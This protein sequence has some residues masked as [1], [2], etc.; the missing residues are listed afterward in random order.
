MVNHRT[1]T[2]AMID[3]RDSFVARRRTDNDVLLPAGP[4]VAITGGPGFNDHHLIW[5]GLP[6]WRGSV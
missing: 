1:L 5:D 6:E 2:S 3:S 4:K